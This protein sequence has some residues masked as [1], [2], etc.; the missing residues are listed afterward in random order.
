MSQEYRPPAK[1]IEGQKLPYP[2]QQSDMRQQP[3][4]D[5]SNYRAAGKLESKV[6]LITGADSG[7]GR[8]V[9]VAFAMEGADVAITYN[10]ND[11]DAEETRR[12]VESKGRRCLLLKFDVRDPEACRKAVAQ[13]VAELG[14]LNVLVNNAHYQ[15]AQKRLEDLTEEQFRLTV[16]TNVLG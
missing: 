4:T 10:V 13:T 1:E 2:A 9:A 12:M 6:S 5:L 14:R 7:I 11:G 3:D 15:M 16:D 8:A